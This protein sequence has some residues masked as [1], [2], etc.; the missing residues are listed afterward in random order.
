VPKLDK[1]EEQLMLVM[2]MLADSLAEAPE[3]EV[4]EEVRQGHESL[5]DESNE[6]RA[7]LGNAGRDHLQRKLREARQ[8]YEA[9]RSQLQ[10]TEYD[11]PSTTSERRNLLYSVLTRRPDFE[12]VVMTTQFRDFKNLTDDDVLSLLRQLKELRLL[13]A[14]AEPTSK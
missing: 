13:D 14:P 1:H 9:A 10:Q 5:L 6:V 4:L 2:N 8:A 7:I 11:L 12:A 3:S